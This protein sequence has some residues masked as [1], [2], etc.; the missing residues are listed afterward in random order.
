M[1]NVE[2]LRQYADSLR[3]TAGSY[4]VAAMC[5]GL[6]GGYDGQAGTYLRHEAD[7]LDAEAR[8]VDSVADG[9]AAR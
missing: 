9:W 1:T 2:N 5:P 6:R 8:T 3:Q 7:R 4:R